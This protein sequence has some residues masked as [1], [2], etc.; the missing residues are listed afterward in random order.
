MW[1]APAA[2]SARTNSASAA[3]SSGGSPPPLW[4][5]LHAAFAADSTSGCDVGLR[6]SAAV[7]AWNTRQSAASWE[8]RTD[9][10]RLW[11]RTQSTTCARDVAAV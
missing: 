5:I 1:W 9:V 6:D 2:T 11:M 4:I 8:K 10:L 3:A 7:I